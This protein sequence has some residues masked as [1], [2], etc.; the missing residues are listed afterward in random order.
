MSR[1]DKVLATHDMQCGH[2]VT[3]AGLRGGR[4]LLSAGRFR[5]SDDGGITWGQWYEGIDEGGEPVRGVCLV[6]LGDGA[7]GMASQRVR[8]GAANRYETEL[9]FRRSE[10]EGKTWSPPAVMNQ[11]LL[12]A[13]ALQ[14]TMLRTTSGRLVQ[15]V[16]MGIGQGLFHQEG[17][18]FV[19]GYLK[20][21]FVSTDAHFYD[22]HFSASYVLY[23]D[24]EG[25]TWQ[26]SHNGELFVVLDEVGAFHGAPEPS[27]VEVE[28]GRLMMI[29]RTRLGRLFQAFSEDDGTTW[30]RLV[31]TQLAGTQ[32]PGQIR[33]F[34]DSGH[35]LVVWT[36]HSEQEVRQGFIRTRLSSAI[37]RNQG[38]CG[39][40]FR[41]SSPFTRRPTWSRV[42]SASP[43]RRAATRCFRP[44]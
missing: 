6:S 41:T 31:P 14:D 20:G 13:H 40:T 21:N 9:L 7:I 43:A 11:C 16:Y 3:F 12:R 29:V 4:I 34:P 32:A 17:M 8:P 35:L 25:Q 15:P 37:S 23:S 26:P 1:P 33:R 19:G 5:V 18:P 10:D 30:S 44:A 39:S 42:R 22:P 27:V 2:G 28:P 38:G 36:Q 24:D